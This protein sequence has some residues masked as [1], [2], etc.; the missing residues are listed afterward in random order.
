M[1]HSSSAVDVLTILYS[2]KKFW[3]DVKW[4]NEDEI[5]K[6]SDHVSFDICRFAVIYFDNI[7]ERIE[8]SEMMANMGIFKIPIEVC[9]AI[10]NIN[11]IS[12]GIQA[13]IS[14]LTA[15]KVQDN[16]RLQKTIASA[17]KHGKSRI[18]KLMKI[19]ITKMKPTIRKLMIEGAEIVKKENEVGERLITYF[20]DCFDTLCNDLNKNDFE[21]CKSILWTTVLDT[22]SEVIATSL[23]T[24]RPPIFFTNLRTIFQALQKDL[25]NENESI[26]M[27]NLCER[28]RQ[29]DFLL[30]RHGLNTPKLIHQYY[31]DRYEMQQQISKSP[32]YPYGMLSI[33]CYFM[34]NVLRLEVLNARNLVPLGANRKP[35]SFVK[36]N[37]VPENEF[38]TNL[39]TF[40]TK[41]G[42]ETHFPLY[43]ELFEL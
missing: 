10:N 37:I 38:P 1:K 42:S 6:I 25:K 21:L 12:L 15:N 40:K 35:D 33:N 23:N 29:I 9:T 22:T 19:S 26:E 5:A 20:D 2:I 41:V 4:P 7:A 3:E 11:H 16:A 27:E 36:I 28:T 32:F 31:K 39:Q 13:L 18:T 43:D 34:H 24:R 8:K 14:E 30:E 17:L